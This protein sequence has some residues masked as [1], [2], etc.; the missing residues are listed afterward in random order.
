MTIQSN[1]CMLFLKIKQTAHELR[2]SIHT[3][4]TLLKV[5]LVQKLLDLR[6][7]VAL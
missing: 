7:L 6:F 4:T 5:L 3:M 2:V 1:H